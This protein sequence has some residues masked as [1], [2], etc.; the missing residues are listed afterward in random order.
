MSRVADGLTQRERE[1]LKLVARGRSSKEIAIELGISHHTVDLHLRHA[2]RT[3][4]ASTRREAARMLSP[5]ELIEAGKNTQ[6]LSSQPSPLAQE[7]F[8]DAPSQPDDARRDRIRIPFLRQ[9]RRSNDLTPIHRLIWIPVLAA[10]MLVGIAN[11][12]NA[13]EALWKI[14]S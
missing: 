14:T 6:V 2:M 9:G 11:F 13:L 1:C 8:F 12:F 4:G 7:R 5:E 10:M 3:L